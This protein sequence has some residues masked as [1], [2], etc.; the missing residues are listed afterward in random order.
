MIITGCEAHCCPC[1]TYGRN[2]YMSS[3]PED[4]DLQNFDSCCNGNVCIPTAL[5][6]TNQANMDSA[7]SFARPDA[8]SLER[9]TS[10]HSSRGFTF[11]RTSSSKEVSHATV[12][13][14][15]A[16]CTLAP[17]PKSKLSYA[18]TESSSWRRTLP[19]DGSTSSHSQVLVA[20]PPWSTPR[21]TPSRRSPN[22]S[23]RQSPQ[24]P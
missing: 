11:E 8:C 7:G 14:S 13:R 5:S 10:G 18:T 2:K 19:C 17:L 22:Q 15:S 21:P 12:F 23:T 1:I 3:H 16:A 9:N 4:K 24:V 20:T 6:L